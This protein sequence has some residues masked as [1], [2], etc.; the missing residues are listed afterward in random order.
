[1]RSLEDITFKSTRP[2]EEFADFWTRQADAVQFCAGSFILLSAVR[3]RSKPVL[4]GLDLVFPFDSG[5]RIPVFEFLK[6]K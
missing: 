5:L 6:W 3:L 1:M 4:F 2:K